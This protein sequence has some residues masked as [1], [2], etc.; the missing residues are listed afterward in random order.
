MP[1][2]FHA[3][4]RT[5]SNSTVL[6]RYMDFAKFI[7]MLESKSLWF[8]RLDQLEDP[9]EG[10]H[11]DAEL[12]SIRK[13][14]EKKRAR[15]L[16]GVFRIARKELY[17]NCWRSGSAESLVMWDLYGKGTGIVAVKSTVERL[18]K[19]VSTCEEPVY[20]SKLRYFD[21]NQAPGL[22]NVLVACSRKE[23][24]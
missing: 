17:V 19:A 16:I 21:W 5:P 15:E 18:K 1:Y 8:T 9:L 11:T 13:N 22:D 3:N 24:S 12:V 23:L 10:G 14:V 2:Q 20:I 6:W 4:L 7:Q